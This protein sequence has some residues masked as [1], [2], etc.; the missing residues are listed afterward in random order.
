M[1]NDYGIKKRRERGKYT[2]TASEKSLGI[3]YPNRRED[4]KKSVT[5]TTIANYTRN[6]KEFSDFLKLEREIRDNQM[7]TIEK[8][9]NEKRKQKTVV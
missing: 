1:A 8:N 5:E 7:D 3:N 6:S 4:Y 9:L 2:V